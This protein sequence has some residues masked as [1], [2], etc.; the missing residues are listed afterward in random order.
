MAS[1]PSL[2]TLEYRLSKGEKSTMGLGRW[3]GPCREW[4]G[5]RVQ[6][7]EMCGA[8]HSCWQILFL[9]CNLHTPHSKLMANSPDGQ[10]SCL[11]HRLSRHFASAMSYCVERSK[12]HGVEMTMS[13]KSSYVGE[14]VW[15]QQI[16]AGKNPIRAPRPAED[17]KSQDP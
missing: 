8:T 4:S 3:S 5:S 1:D 9:L 12:D 13:F 17:L 16:L 14:I 6:G 15:H 2:P 10:L 11:G 7:R